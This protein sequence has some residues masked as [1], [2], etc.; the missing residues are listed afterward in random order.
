[1]PQSQVSARLAR[2]VLRMAETNDRETIYHLRHEIYAR[3]LVQH[4]TSAEARLIDSL[5]AFNV[6]VVGCGGAE[7]A[8]FISIT[9]PGHGRYSIDKYIAREELPFPVDDR[10]YEMRLLTVLPAYRN[11][12]AA[13]LL[14]YAAVV[15][16]WSRGGARIVAIGRQEV[17]DLYCRVGME[18]HG[19]EIRSGAV[20]FELMSAEVA[21]LHRRWAQYSSI[22]RKLKPGVD[23]Q[24]DLPYDPPD[25][26]FHGG[27]SIEAVGD[28]F[29]ALE[30]R[31]EVINADVLDAWFPPAPGVIA[32]LRECLSWMARTSPPAHAEG[33]VRTIA[34]VRGI[35]DAS[36]LPGAGSSS[37]IFLVLREWLTAGSRVLVLDP[38]YGEY[39]Y[40]FAKVK[41][42][43]AVWRPRRISVRPPRSNRAIACH[44]PALGAKPSR[45]GCRGK[46][47]TRSG[48]LC[49]V[50]LG[51]AC[52]AG[53]FA[54]RPAKDR[55]GERRTQHYQLPAVPTGG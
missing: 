19:R 10:L 49:R 51:D 3:E 26:C 47:A 11:T 55:R 37:L 34:K 53:R 25:A 41:G 24:L 23:W 39:P 15:W 48:L 14:M 16:I 8:G 46:G 38:S 42:L 18:P 40:L 17:R 22:L 35:P 52:I 45:A 28:T 20:T 43:C 7:I 2:L 50:L 4:E 54:K 27:A 21:V 32:A 9:P 44:V 33:L 29:E 36:V 5:D 31:S 1:M 30:R 13:F 12:R 6:Y